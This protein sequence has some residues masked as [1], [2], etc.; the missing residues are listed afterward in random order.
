MRLVTSCLIAAVVVTLSTSLHAQGRGGR[1]DQGRGHAGGKASNHHPPDSPPVYT[2][3]EP[4]V[5]TMLALGVGAAALVR[6]RRRVRESRS[7]DTP[8]TD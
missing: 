4:A 8:A 6:T 7:L 2:V 5:L 3:A 1:Q